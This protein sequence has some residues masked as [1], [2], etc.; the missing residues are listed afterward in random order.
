MSLH[1]RGLTVAES[2]R[3]DAILPTTDS[4]LGLRIYDWMF[5]LAG[6]GVAAVI[7]LIA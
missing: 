2:Q 6:V 1:H 7:I 4:L 5:L 3:R